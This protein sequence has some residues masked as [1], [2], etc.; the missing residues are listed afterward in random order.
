MIVNLYRKNSNIEYK[1]TKSLKNLG[2]FYNKIKKTLTWNS[3]YRRAVMRIKEF[4]LYGEV[5]KIYH[6][7]G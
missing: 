7:G 5:R 3:K 2:L 4:I 6:S 1:I